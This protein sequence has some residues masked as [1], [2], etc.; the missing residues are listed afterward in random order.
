MYIRPGLACGRYVSGSREGHLHA[1]VKTPCERAIVSAG[2]P[3]IERPRGISALVRWAQIRRRK[4]AGADRA[5]ANRRRDPFLLRIGRS[6][7]APPRRHH[8]V[9]RPKPSTITTTPH[10]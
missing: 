5:R 9:Q 10:V 8:R 4:F 2:A 1:L 6:R 7:V 3:Q